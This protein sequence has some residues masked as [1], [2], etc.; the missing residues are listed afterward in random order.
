MHFVVRTG[1]FGRSPSDGSRYRPFACRHLVACSS[2]YATATLLPNMD[3]PTPTFTA[4]S[5][6]WRSDAGHLPVRLFA[7]ATIALTLRTHTAPTRHGRTVTP[8]THC[9]SAFA[10]NDAH[11]CSDGGPWTSYTGFIANNFVATTRSAVRLFTPLFCR[12]VTNLSSGG[13]TRRRLPARRCGLVVLPPVRLVTNK[14]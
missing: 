11:T 3:V 4:G 7:N 10:V 5:P 14:L 9:P 12:L 6:A 8:L 13:L 2:C 1:P